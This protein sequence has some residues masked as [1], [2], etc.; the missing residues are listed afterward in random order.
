MP[1]VVAAAG[2]R[3]PCSR[4]VPG[5]PYLFQHHQLLPLP[6]TSGSKCGVPDVLWKGARLPPPRSL[7]SFSGKMQ[8]WSP[9]DLSGPPPDCSVGF[10][11]RTSGKAPVFTMTT[12]AELVQ[13]GPPFRLAWLGGLKDLDQSLEPAMS[14]TDPGG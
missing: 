3:S 11:G 8:L 7:R 6:L 12:M 10:P 1:A 9:K 14:A 2:R 13:P 5:R 4:G